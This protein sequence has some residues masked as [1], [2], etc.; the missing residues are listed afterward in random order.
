MIWCI[1]LGSALTV[2]TVGIQAAGTAWWIQRLKRTSV[3]VV[4]IRRRL[5]P[6]RLLCS[7]ALL[8][9]LLHIL[10]VVPWAV[11]YVLL[12]NLNSLNSLEEATYFATVTFTSL[13]Y[14]DVVIRGPWRLLSGIQAMNGLLVFGWSTAL[15]FAVVQRIWGA[16]EAPQQKSSRVDVQLAT[17]TVTSGGGEPLRNAA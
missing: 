6:F 13:G 11:A 14:G 3:P 2:L 4:G 10:E 5:L 17:T 8:L 15:L 12:P 1:L 7:T 9:I 16:D